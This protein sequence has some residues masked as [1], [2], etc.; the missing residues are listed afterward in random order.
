MLFAN[1]SALNGEPPA[2]PYAAGTPQGVLDNVRILR[3][4]D[5]EMAERVIERDGAHLAAVL[6]DPMP[7]RMGLIPGTH[8]FLSGLRELTKAHGILLIFDEVISL[9]ASWHGTQGLIG[10]TPD[11]TTMAK[12]IGGGF[13]V[14]AVGGSNRSIRRRG[15]RR[16]SLR[17]ANARR[18]STTG[19][20]SSNGARI[21]QR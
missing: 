9:R 17:S 15:V 4:N 14:G 18:G 6:V 16:P 5:L 8:E 2:I 19:H 7:W 3:F 11:L 20:R 21:G 13:P 1:I 12:I 10:V